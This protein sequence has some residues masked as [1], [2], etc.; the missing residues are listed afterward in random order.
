MSRDRSHHGEADALVRELFP[1]AV[2]ITPNL[3]EAGLL[4]GRQLQSTDDMAWAAQQLKAQGARA[5]LVKRHQR[6]LALVDELAALRLRAWPVK[7]PP[8]HG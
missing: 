5:V 2:L 7:L 3:D 8:A 6:M 4:V 1:R